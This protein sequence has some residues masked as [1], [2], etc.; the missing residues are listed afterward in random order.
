M[1]EKINLQAKQFAELIGGTLESY[2]DLH[3]VFYNYGSSPSLAYWVGKQ[4]HPKN[5]FHFLDKRVR[6]QSV[7]E[8]RRRQVRS[9]LFHKGLRKIR[10]EQARCPQTGKSRMLSLSK[11]QA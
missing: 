1:K 7:E 5:T 10:W 9:K 4:K 3:F 6:E 8:L 11:Q 2:R